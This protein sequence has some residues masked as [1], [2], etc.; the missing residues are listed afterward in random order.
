MDFKSYRDGFIAGLNIKENHKVSL[1]G[2]E[3]NELLD[4]IEKHLIEKQKSEV[5]DIP[6]GFTFNWH[7]RKEINNV[8]S[9]LCKQGFKIYKTKE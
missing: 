1:L 2:L 9:E 4:I 8:F 5:P 7:N 6:L 3:V